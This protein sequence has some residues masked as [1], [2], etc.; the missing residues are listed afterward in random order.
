MPENQYV[1]SLLFTITTGSQVP[2]H[3][4][5]YQYRANLRVIYATIET[6]YQPI[7]ATLHYLNIIFELRIN[8]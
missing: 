1:F 8:I 2:L 3:F 7:S 5:D 6:D 4:A